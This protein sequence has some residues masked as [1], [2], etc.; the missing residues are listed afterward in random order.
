MLAWLEAQGHWGFIALSLAVTFALVLA[1]LLPPWL[2]QRR[3]R[4][5]IRARLRRE[6]ADAR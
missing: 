5:Q 2:R 6:R 3:L 1:D 4:S